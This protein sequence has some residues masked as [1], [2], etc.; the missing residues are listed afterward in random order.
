MLQQM[1][2]LHG[3]EINSE[4]ARKWDWKVAPPT[5]YPKAC[6]I[7]KSFT[8]P[9]HWNGKPMV[10][11]DS[12]WPISKHSSA[13]VG[14][15]QRYESEKGQCKLNIHFVWPAGKFSCMSFHMDAGEKGEEPG[16]GES[17]SEEDDDNDEESSEQSQVEEVPESEQ[18]Q[19]IFIH[20]IT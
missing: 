12:T 20:T 5:T 7:K 19:Q 8:F 1:L 6:D 2:T 3:K 15:I 9:F 10:L 18:G 13:P 16:S 14:L 4:Q 11:H 17:S